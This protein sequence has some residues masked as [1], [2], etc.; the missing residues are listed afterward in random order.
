MIE[1][2]K[3]AFAIRQKKELKLEKNFAKL[4]SVTEKYL[5]T[6]QVKK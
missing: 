1:K 4:E 6:L 3:K 2:L 5:S